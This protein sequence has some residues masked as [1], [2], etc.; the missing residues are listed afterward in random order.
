MICIT[1]IGDALGDLVP[2][3]QLKK[4][5]KRQWRSITFSFSLPK[6]TLT[7]LVFF[8]FF[9][10][11]KWYQFAQSVTFGKYYLMLLQ[12]LYTNVSF[13]IFIHFLYKYGR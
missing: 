3:V 8:T 7:A 6:L 13:L 12:I 1:D 2:F 4:R 9:K 5:E 11:C 10:L